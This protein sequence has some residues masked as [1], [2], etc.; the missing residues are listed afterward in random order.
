MLKDS[1]GTVSEE[2]ALWLVND[3]FINIAKKFSAK[4]D[5]ERHRQ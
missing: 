1:N 2:R 4:E 3:L 5:I